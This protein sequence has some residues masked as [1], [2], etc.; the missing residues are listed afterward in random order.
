[1][2]IVDAK[3]GSDLDRSIAEPL[4]AQPIT[5]RLAGAGSLRRELEALLAAAPPEASPV[6]F[7]DLL[8]GCKRSE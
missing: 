7:R 6:L 2:P 3:E 8:I 1:M 4:D 5:A